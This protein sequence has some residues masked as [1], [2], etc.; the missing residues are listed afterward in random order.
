MLDGWDTIQ[1]AVAGKGWAPAV[2]YTALAGRQLT[3]TPLDPIVRVAELRPVAFRSH[4]NGRYSWAFPQ[5]FGGYA[6]LDVP[7][8]GF[9]KTTLV[10]QVG[11]V[12][13]ASGWPVPNIVQIWSAPSYVC[14][15]ALPDRAIAPWKG[16][17]CDL[18]SSPS[19]FGRGIRSENGPF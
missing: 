9:V 15:G 18:K 5:K 13:D 11:E 19:A 12:L 14:S 4:G 3:P 17:C 16:L 10:V 8:A 6:E 1:Y 2:V 7:S